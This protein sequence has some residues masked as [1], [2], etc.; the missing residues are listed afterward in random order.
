[1]GGEKKCFTRQREQ[2][3]KMNKEYLLWIIWQDDGKT[4]VYAI[5]IDSKNSVHGF[6]FNISRIEAIN[7]AV[8]YVVENNK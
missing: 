3:I 8:N 5:Q 4:N 2:F 7:E 1:L 6:S